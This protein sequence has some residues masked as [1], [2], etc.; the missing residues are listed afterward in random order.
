MAEIIHGIGIKAPVSDVY[1]ALS[2]IDG[3]A[4]WWTEETTGESKPGGN[5][6]FT[7]RTPDGDLKGMSVMKVTSLEPN[8]RVAWRC[9][10]GPPEWIGTELK[11]ELKQEGENNTMV[12]F[13]HHKW[14]E[15]TQ[16]IA[17]CSMKWAVF[18]LSLRDFVAKG[19][20]QPSPY[21][22]KID[23]WN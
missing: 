14:P 12:L 18:L 5:I 20:G 10:E 11:F 9:V 1:K 23:A 13:G 3:L 6:T 19:K 16:F 21:D 8:K 2:T 15:G 22:M 4:G 17:H 7:F